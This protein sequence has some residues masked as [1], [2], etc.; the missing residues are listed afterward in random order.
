MMGD[1]V[2]RNRMGCEE[3]GP[4]SSKSFS[5]LFYELSLWDLNS[6]VVVQVQFDLDFP[7]FFTGFGCSDCFCC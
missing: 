6:M 4:F 2:L 5:L 1:S 7:T 3:L